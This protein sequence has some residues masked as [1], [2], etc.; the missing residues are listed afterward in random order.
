MAASSAADMECSWPTYTNDELLLE[1]VPFRSMA[2]FGDSFSDVGNIHIASN[3]SQPGTWSW[4]GRYADGRLWLEHV[5]QFFDLPQVTPS[6]EGGTGYALGGAT[7][8]DGYIESFSTYL[9]GSVPGVRQQVEAYIRDHPSSVV[10]ESLHVIYGG[11]NDYWWYVH[12]NFTTSDGQDLNFTNV[13]A[14]IVGQ[15]IDNVQKLYDAGARQFLVANLMNMSTWAESE[16]QS[17]QTL[18]AYDVLVAGHNAL[19][20]VRLSEFK[21]DH[22][23]ATV[24]DFDVFGA[25]ECLNERQGFFGMQNVED[26]CHPSQAEHCGDIFS[27]KFWDWYHPTTHAH[28]VS[29]MTAIQS[30]YDGI[31]R[32]GQEK[33]SGSFRGQV[34]IH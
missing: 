22:A 32:T 18:N 8:D 26:P 2:I 19:L 15:A 28:Q 7:M 6:W 30:L 20:W 25:F 34:A 1:N 5:A 13:Y 23:D 17:P 16:V 29:S 27:F 9:N 21:E 14:N 24:Y 3:G 11:Y 10:D 4:E 33:G 12:R 31:S